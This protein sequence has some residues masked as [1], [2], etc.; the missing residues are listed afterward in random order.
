MDAYLGCDPGHGRIRLPLSGSLDLTYRCN[1]AC[2]HCWVRLPAG[3]PERKREMTASEILALAREARAMGC[4]KWYVSGGEPLLR[5]D[6]E[7]I[8]KGLLDASGGLVLN[9]N[10]TLMTPGLARLLA[11]RKARTLVS[12]YGATA[13]THDLITG[14]PGSFDAMRKGVSLLEKAGAA[15]TIQAVPMKANEAEFRAML[16]LAG[17]LGDVTRLGASWLYCAGDR[18]PRRNLEILA[19]RL[20]P[21]RAVEFDPPALPSGDDEPA[22]AGCGARA[23]SGALYAGCIMERDAFHLDPYGGLSFCPFIRDPALRSDARTTGF[24]AGWEEFLP[25]LRNRVKPGRAYREACGSCERRADCAWCPAFA[26]LE[27]GR[28]DRKIEYLCRVAEETRRAKEEKMR[29]Q[30]LYFRVAGITIRVDSDLPFEPETF[31]PKLRKFLAGG[32]GPDMVSLRYHFSLPPLDART[33]G[34][35][36]LRELPWKIYS[37]R[38]SWVY[39]CGPEKG[40]PYQIGVFGGDYS[41]GDIY[42]RDDAYFRRGGV[43]SLTMFST[44]Q[45]LLSQLLADR[46]GCFFHAAG[47]DVGGRGVLFVGHSEAGKSTLA[48]MLMPRAE[49]LCDDR[50]IV[51]RDGDGFR[52]HGNWGHGEIPIVSA[53]SAPLAAVFFPV[54]SARNEAV[55]VTGTAEKAKRL[56]P[57][58]IR[59]LETSRWWGKS[60]GFLDA[61]AAAIPCYDLHFDLSG[62]AAEVVKGVIGRR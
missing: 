45:I 20:D 21:A 5:P 35:P 29:R 3:A 44:D 46:D 49:I 40:R 6:F 36:V 1:N 7:R 57:C 8:L 30:R 51:R 34:R 39:Y 48:K 17:R 47:L 31:H 56:L 4:R 41:R 18:D 43:L 28:H 19:Q 53:S 42:N 37:S 13:G 9:T 61:F 59:P 60:L 12:L 22:A 16:R 54:K 25:S 27:H 32:P 58:L 55:P 62:R 50:M 52:I 38:G 2:L 14:R 26:Y 10:A 33:L 15:V 24:R 11:S 23:G